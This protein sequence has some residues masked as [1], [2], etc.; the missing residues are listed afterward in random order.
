MCMCLEG[1]QNFNTAGGGLHD[2]ILIL[3]VG[4]NCIDFYQLQGIIVYKN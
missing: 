1:F 3:T 2:Y 4:E